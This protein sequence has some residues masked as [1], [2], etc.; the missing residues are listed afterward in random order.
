MSGY[1]EMY[2]A[3]RDAQRI[4]SL[5]KWVREEKLDRDALALIATWYL[6]HKDMIELRQAKYKIERLLKSGI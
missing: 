3:D 2:Q 6:D 5:P 1:S 4:K